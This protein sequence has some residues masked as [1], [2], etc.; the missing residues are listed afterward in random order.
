[1]APSNIISI[2]KGICPATEADTEKIV[3]STDASTIKGNPLAILWPENAEQLQ[4]VIRYTQREGLS[5]TVRGGGTSLV[6]GAVPVNSIVVDMSRLNKIKRIDLKENA[7][8]VEA[9][10]VLD[11]LNNALAKYGYEFPIKPGSHA[12]CTV[13]GI[14]ATNAGGMLTPKFG[15]VSEWISAA[16]IMDGTGK[17][18]DFYDNQAR[19][20]AGTE[21]CV[22]I[23]LEAKLKL[24]E[25]GKYYSTDLYE[26]E[27]IQNLI[28]KVNDLKNDPDAVAIEYIN[29]IAAGIA[30]MKQKDYL[31]VKYKGTKGNLDSLK[32]EKL[33]KLRENIYSILYEKGY[34]I[35]EDP[36]IEKDMDKF[37]DWLNKQNIP[38]FGHIAYGV[39]HPH[40]NS[41]EHAEKMYA[42]VKE[43][44]G[45]L[46]GEHGIGLLKRKVAPL[47]IT[48]KIKDL[49]AK[50]DPNNILNKGKVI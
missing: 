31:L 34:K 23:I 36:I 21:G 12:S 13:G 43:L 8:F 26:F 32:A 4:K 17:V 38:C 9:G 42:A 16:R 10:V 44:G 6:G 50:Y 18:F 1:M 3:Y 28:E 2:L 24:S 11:D 7:V 25:L 5:L 19:E 49:K 33:W 40:F 45:K 35:I 29:S 14:I 30:G 27:N 37:V 20:V 41:E 15:K 22:M 46:C 39:L 48:Q 47:I